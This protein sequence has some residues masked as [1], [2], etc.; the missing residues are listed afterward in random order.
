MFINIDK[1]MFYLVAN[2]N[3]MLIRLVAVS[4]PDDLKSNVAEAYRRASLF[5]ERGDAP[6]GF[7][8]LAQGYKSVFDDVVNGRL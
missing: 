2:E 6:V 1:V 3:E 7:T 8:Y 5:L 4:K